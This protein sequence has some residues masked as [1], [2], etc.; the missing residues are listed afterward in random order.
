MSWS[1]ILKSVP[2]EFSDEERDLSRDFLDNLKSY[3][4][5]RPELVNRGVFVDSGTRLRNN[6]NL[7]NLVTSS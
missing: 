4:D 2:G 3:K 6:S 1:F 7:P 5:K